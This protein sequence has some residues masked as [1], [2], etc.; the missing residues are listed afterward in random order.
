MLKIQRITIKKN[1]RALLLRNGDF[2]RVLHSGRHW[3]FAGTDQLR[4][5]TFAL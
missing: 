4:V 2:E 3:L 1:E 5:E